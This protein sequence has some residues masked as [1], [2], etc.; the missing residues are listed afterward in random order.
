MVASL[1]PAAI[2]RLN[3]TDF[4]TTT[5]K[6][7][8]WRKAW[9]PLSFE[10]REDTQ[11]QTRPAQ[12]QMYCHTFPVRLC[13]ALPCVFLYLARPRE[14]LSQGRKTKLGKNWRKSTLPLGQTRTTH[15][16]LPL[17]VTVTRWLLPLALTATQQTSSG[18][19]LGLN[20]DETLGFYSGGT[21]VKRS[22]VENK[23]TEEQKRKTSCVPQQS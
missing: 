6:P 12:K 10:T 14:A 19:E 20:P 18:L 16:I 2:V 22:A 9:F 7:T 5:V 17:V 21:K 15:W 4:K 3:L 13:S 23:R 1:R 11:K 8:T